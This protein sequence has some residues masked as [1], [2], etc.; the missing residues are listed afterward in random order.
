MTTAG[1]PLPG[2]RNITNTT[3]SQRRKQIYLQGGVLAITSRILVVDMLNE[4]IP[5]EIITGI[6]IVDAHKVANEESTEHFILRIY[7]YHN[8]QS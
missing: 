3:N 2:L 7:R 6:V 5:T 8:T 1:I 4:L